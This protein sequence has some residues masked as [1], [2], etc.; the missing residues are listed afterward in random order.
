EE[1]KTL[2]DFLY[3]LQELLPSYGVPHIIRLVEQHHKTTSTMKIIKA[4]L[5]TERFKQ[6]EKYPHFILYQG[7][8]VRLTKDLLSALELG[9]LTLGFW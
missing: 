5:Q 6:I 4:N 2:N 9:K 1:G 3:Q 8:Y 7:R